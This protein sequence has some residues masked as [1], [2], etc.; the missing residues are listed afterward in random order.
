[1]EK[2]ILIVGRHW[3][4]HGFPNDR[5]AESVRGALDN[6]KKALGYSS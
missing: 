1:M 3:E 2:M 4:A 6:L 5:G